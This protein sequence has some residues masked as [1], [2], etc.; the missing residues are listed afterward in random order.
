MV[1]MQYAK[2]KKMRSA[3]QEKEKELDD[4]EEAF[5]YNSIYARHQVG[6][7]Y[8]H[9]HPMREQPLSLN[10]ECSQ[11]DV[12]PTMLAFGRAMSI[13]DAEDTVIPTQLR[14]KFE[15][16]ESV[17]LSATI[18]GDE[19]WGSL[20][21]A[22]R[23]RVRRLELEDTILT[24][25]PPRVKQAITKNASRYTID[26]VENS[27][28]YVS[29]Q[30]DITDPADEGA[31]AVG[32][33][34]GGASM[35]VDEAVRDVG[36]E[37]VV[38]GVL[39][40]PPRDPAFQV[41]GLAH[42]YS[43]EFEPDV[44]LM[45][46]K[47][48]KHWPRTEYIKP[49]VSLPSIANM[50]MGLDFR[51]QADLVHLLRQSV[52]D[53]SE[54][55]RL[56]ALSRSDV[57]GWDDIIREL[58]MSDDE[59]LL[60]WNV[61]R[62]TAASSGTWM[63]SMIEYMLNGYKI[64][65]GPMRGEMES[66]IKFLSSLEN[67]EVYRTEW[68]ICA[69][70]EDLAGSIN[71][72]VKDKDHNTFHIVD[73]KRSE[74]LEEKYTSHGMKMTPPAHDVEDC[75]GRLRAL[76][77]KLMRCCR[78]QKAAAS[79][80]KNTDPDEDLTK[81]QEVLDR[82]VGDEQM[83]SMHD[84]R[85]DVPDTVPFRVMLTGQDREK[86]DMEIALEE[87]MLEE[88]DTDAPLFAKKRRLMSGAGSHAQ[89]CKRMFQRS[90]DIIKTTLD[91]YGADVCLQPNTIMQNTRNML[92]S[93]QIKYPWMS[94]QLRRLIMIAAHM[95]T[96][97]ITDKTMLP[98]AAAI[99]W[100]VEGDGHMR[101]HK[102]F[103][104]VYDDDRCFMPFGGIPPEAVLH[105]IHDFFCCLEGIFRRMKPEI[106]RDANSVADAIAADMQSCETE[107]DY[108]TFCRT[109]TSR[110][111][112]APAYS[113][114][115]DAEDEG[116]GLPV[117]VVKK[118]PQNDSYVK[119]PHPL[120]DPVMD[121]NMERLQLFY[122]RTFW[123]NLDV[124]KCFQA[125]IA[126]A[127]RG[128]NVDRCFIGISPGGVGQSLYSHHLSE[129]YKHN[130]SYFDP[131]IWHLDEELRK[132]VESFAKCFILTGQE[133]PETSRKLHIDLYKK[134]ISGDGIMGRK[135]YGWTRL[136]VNKMMS[137][138]GVTNS[139]FNSMF[140]R[141]FVWKAKARFIH[142]KF[143]R[144]YN[145]HEKASVAE[146]KLQW[147]F[148]VDHN[149]ED[150]YQLIEDYCNGGDG[151][152]TEDVMREACGLPVRVRQV[153]E[154][155][156]LGNLLGA[157][158]DSADE[159]EEKNSEWVNLRNYITMHMLDKDLDIMTWYEFKRMSFKPGEHPNLSKAAMW[160]QLKEKPGA[161]IPRMT[162]AKEHCDI[163]PQR[164]LDTV[165]MQFDEEID[166]G[167]ARRY[168]YIC[169][170]HGMNMDN[171]K[172]FYK[173]MLPVSRK[174]RRSAEQEE[175][176]STYQNLLRKLEEHE[177]SLTNLLATKHGGRLRTK[178]SVED[179]DP[180]ASKQGSPDGREY[181]SLKHSRTTSYGYSEKLSYTVRARRYATTDGVQS[182]SRRLQLHVVDGHTIDLDIQNCCLTLL[183][184]ILA[185]TVP[186]P[187]MPDDLA[188]LMD[189]LVK[190]RAGVL[191]QIGLHIVEG[192]EMINTV[193][194]GGNPPTS[195]KNNELI[196]GLQKISLYIR[197]VACN[198]LHADYM[199]LQKLSHRPPFYPLCGRPSKT[200]SCKAGPTTS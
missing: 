134:T 187:A 94:E 160:D 8:M 105:C 171:M 149:K 130:H 174:G 20:M 93:L 62:Q 129:M 33:G 192:K 53:M 195:L 148:E 51:C 69:P 19:W 126:I 145:D 199:S 178:R 146:L 50:L 80:Q 82:Q 124:L 12:S 96:G 47:S 86:D 189:R 118:G 37:D 141:A 56:F 188:H 200:G 198:L 196:Q 151:H 172:A 13:M 92:S 147:A 170:V 44:A 5:G 119:I 36:L 110:R 191:K 95:S 23:A 66:V 28:V 163:C 58:T 142:E 11:A 21:N 114:R 112:Q 111:S 25:G 107:A 64:N 158:Q 182:M 132:Q 113:Q 91:V 38:G 48:G 183:Q 81:S 157:G 15:P 186:Q 131:N 67:V 27:Q 169:R 180:E 84:N 190:D 43:E 98:D 45:K 144:H 46:M 153:Q 17:N 61:R 104:F 103:L 41:T 9:L 79:L 137:F 14:V 40:E 164:S 184:Q 136:E 39:L 133:V 99:T 78:D 54:I 175:V 71:L 73:W 22:I 115:L 176:R 68:C 123:C 3:I 29:S 143:L 138:I 116:C 59:I 135:P 197:W 1:K 97:K 117:D 106:N 34:E 150:C 72:V 101:V 83:Q 108:L 85:D 120:L 2:L 100:M 87:I 173:S 125:A 167:L 42:R 128:F 159:R 77:E 52:P 76:V 140:R 75:Q 35:D 102:G 26:V 156:G 109:A 89:D 179:D 88:D 16:D 55:C 168:A 155:D 70:D 57:D 90:L 177:R 4:M 122:E 185:Q 49:S 193:L 24:K 161:Y 63:H 7:R 60:N 30:M 65:P 139:N 6:R 10:V 166:I 121:A 181:V 31:E 194:N 162:F 154:E 127:K 18:L 152:L 32:T 165:R 74:K